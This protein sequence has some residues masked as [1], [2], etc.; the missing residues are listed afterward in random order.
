MADAR[1]LAGRL[2]E[3]AANHLGEFYTAATDRVLD[4]EAADYLDRLP[5]PEGGGADT[6]RQRG[7]A[8]P[9]DHELRDRAA[10]STLPAPAASEGE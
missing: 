2:R 4:L 7:G 5:A 6:V 3:R 8:L 10:L 1:A 9:G